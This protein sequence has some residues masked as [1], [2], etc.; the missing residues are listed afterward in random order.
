MTKLKKRSYDALAVRNSGGKWFTGWEGNAFTDAIW[1]SFKKKYPN[2]DDQY[3]FSKNSP[4]E[5]V[6]IID[7]EVRKLRLQFSSTHKGRSS[8]IA[9][10]FDE[11]GFGYDISLNS[12]DLLLCLI[13][14]KPGELHTQ[15][16]ISEC[17]NSEGTWIEGS[18]VQCKKGQNYFIEPFKVS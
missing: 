1:E 13:H 9:V 14:Q 3:I 18:F 16:D 5:F 15:Y 17:R 8:A 10:F 11:D 2:A 12:L 7:H 6:D 4:N